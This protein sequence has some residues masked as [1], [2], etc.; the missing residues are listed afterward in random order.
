MAD[1]ILGDVSPSGKL[2]VT[3]YKGIDQLP[4]FEDYA[5]KGR[6]YRY[7]EGEPLFPFGF[8][9]SYTTFSYGEAYVDGAH[10]LVPVTNTGSRTA[11][12]VVQLYVRRPDDTDGPLKSLRGFKRVTIAPGETKTVAIPLTDDTFLGWSPD[13][14][15]MVPMKGRWELLYGSSSAETKKLECTY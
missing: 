6:T 5:M 13:A 8:G 12:E 7:F 2:P 14:Q 9:L 3:F 15:D 11:D 10:L 1:I 4:P